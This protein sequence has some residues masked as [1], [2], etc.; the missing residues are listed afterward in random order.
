MA[1][2]VANVFFLSELRHSDVF[3]HKFTSP[4]KP[5]KGKRFGFLMEVGAYGYCID[6]LVTPDALS[7]A[8]ENANAQNLVYPRGM[9]FGSIAVFLAGVAGAK[10]GNKKRHSFEYSNIEDRLRQVAREAYPVHEFMSPLRYEITRLE[11]LPAT[12][13]VE[14]G[15]HVIYHGRGRFAARTVNVQFAAR[16]IEKFAYNAYQDDY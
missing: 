4:R 9:P 16:G 3:P 15:D 5:V 11:L 2:I 6:R 7:K 8:A 12:L 10:F 14:A 1:V 13:R